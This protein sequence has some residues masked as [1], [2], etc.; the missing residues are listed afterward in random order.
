M[1]SDVLVTD[2]LVQRIRDMGDTPPK[3]S[4]LNK[5]LTDAKWTK[6]EGQVWWRGW[7]APRSKANRIS[8]LATSDLAPA[9]QTARGPAIVGPFSWR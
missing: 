3:T 7:M 8:M 4:A 6:F 5:M 9:K 1:A 2:C